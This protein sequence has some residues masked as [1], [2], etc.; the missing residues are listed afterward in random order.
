MAHPLA[1]LILELSTPIAEGLGL[2][3][4]EVI[5]HTH[6]N[7][8]VLRVNICNPNQDTSLDDCEKMS[9]ALEPILDQAQLIPNA[10]V[11]EVSSPGVP[12]IL[13]SDREFTSFKGFNV[14]VTTTESWQ[15]HSQWSGRLISR[16]LETIKLNLKGRTISIPRHLI[17]TVKLTESD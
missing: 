5:F 7:P 3:V 1:P 4:V 2:D 11:L 12:Q 15:G 13:S 10:Y 17:S 9:L 8:P 14:L 6:Y 16:N